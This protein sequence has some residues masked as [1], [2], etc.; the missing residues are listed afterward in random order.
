M[1]K[2]ITAGYVTARYLKAWYATAG[3]IAAR[4][5]IAVLKR[6]R[7]RLDTCTTKNYVDYGVR[8]RPARSTTFIPSALSKHAK[9]TN[10]IYMN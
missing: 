5:I 10:D 4:C 7:P 3:Y 2:Y 6:K 8:K 9:Q 1:A